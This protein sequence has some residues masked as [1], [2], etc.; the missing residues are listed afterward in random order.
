MAKLRNRAAR[1]ARGG[2]PGKTGKAPDAPRSHSHDRRAIPLKA[3]PPAFPVDLIVPAAKGA[4]IRPLDMPQTA[5][6]PLAVAGRGFDRLPARSKPAQP[7]QPD[8]P[9]Q[10]LECAPALALPPVDAPCADQPAPGEP[11]QRPDAPL[12][13]ARA[14]A[15]R[16]QGFIDVLAFMLR[17]SGRRLARWSSARRRADEARAKLARTEAKLRAIEAQLA[18]LR[19]LQEHVRQT[20]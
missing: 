2:S 3:A 19:A 20:G 5:L 6:V 7:V 13:A 15:P 10:R 11:A 9:V 18:A 16:R 12:P 14:L 4:V 8:Q 17:D 1:K